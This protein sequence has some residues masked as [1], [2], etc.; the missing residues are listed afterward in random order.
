MHF[1][2]LLDEFLESKGSRELALNALGKRSSVPASTLRRIVA[3]ENE[4]PPQ[5]KTT[6]AILGA[7]ATREK[8]LEALRELYPEVMRSM[9]G[10]FTREN[11]LQAAGPDELSRLYTHLLLRPNCRV[12][13]LCATRSGTT[14]AEVQSLLGAAGLAALDSLIDDDLVAETRE[15]ILRLRSPNF[16][17]MSGDVLK[18]VSIALA[19]EFNVGNLGT[20]KALLSQLSESVNEE[21][22]GLIKKALLGCL[23]EIDAIRANHKYAGTHVFYASLMLNTLNE[24]PLTASPAAAKEQT[25][26]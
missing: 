14:R 15:G 20:N 11:G 4:Q 12:V 9:E 1:Y 24:V 22:L 2:K 25:H 18:G 23:R 8:A 13:H 26:A 21:G 16:S 5:F 7:I 17:I 10:I 19:E 3:R 6:A